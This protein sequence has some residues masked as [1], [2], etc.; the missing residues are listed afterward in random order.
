[1]Y[2]IQDIFASLKN[3]LNGKISFENISF[4]K[5][6][7]W[8]SFDHFRDE[9]RRGISA[10]LTGRWRKDELVSDILHLL[11]TEQEDKVQALLKKEFYSRVMTVL[12]SGKTEETH[13]AL[14][15]ARYPAEWY[16]RARSLKRTIHLHVGPTNSGKTY[17]ALKRLQEVEGDTIY[18]GPLRMLAHEVYTRLNALGKQT[19]LVT[20]D[21]RQ[22]PIGVEPEDYASARNV[23]CTVEMIPFNHEY[24]VA[25]IDEIQ[26]IAD[27][28]RGGSWTSAVLGLPAKELHLCGEERAV[29]IVRQIIAS[30]G[31]KLVI[32]RYQRLTPLE[33]EDRPLTSLGHLQKGD[34]LVSFSVASIHKLRDRIQRATGKQCAI[35]YG[36]LP[37]EVR[38]QQ[39]QLFNDP[40]NDHD[41][42]VAS[43][44]IGMGL[45]LAIKRVIFEATVKNRRD[46]KRSEL[47]VPEIKQ[48]GG[49]AGR[50]RTSYQDTNKPAVAAQPDTVATAAP[51]HLSPLL[52]TQPPVSDIDDGLLLPDSTVPFL[53]E[54][55]DNTLLPNEEVIEEEGATPKEETHPPPSKSEDSLSLAGSISAL[56]QGDLETVRRAFLSEPPPITQ[57]AIQ[58]SQEVISRFYGYFPPGIPYSYIFVRLLDLTELNTDYFLQSHFDTIEI[59]DA[60]ESVADLRIED[61]IA[62]CYAP[63]PMRL[64]V[65]VKLIREM[66]RC[67]ATDSGGSL[68]QLNCISLDVLDSPPDDPDLLPKLETLH[69]GLVLYSWMS[70]RFPGVFVDRALASLTRT[71]TQDAINEALALQNEASRKRGGFR[72]SKLTPRDS[73]EVEDAEFTSSFQP[74]S[75]SEISIR[76]QTGLPIRLSS[77]RN[78]LSQAPIREQGNSPIPR[79][80]MSV[81]APEAPI[82][83]SVSLRR[84]LSYKNFDDEMSKSNHLVQPVDKLDPNL[85]SHIK[86]SKNMDRGIIPTSTHW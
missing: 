55:S 49:R 78:L 51:N 43:D 52:L 56:T 58:P 5:A 13:K 64:N 32:H 74:A 46:Q 16:P 66:A 25:V 1:M 70:F 21:E 60:I 14:A 45:N 44:A 4:N 48:I 30:T 19:W 65:M 40:N 77:G 72:I 15:D 11:E 54:S 17:H 27:P 80:R 71:L 22:Y 6:R 85:S 59:A 3:E 57:A 53:K 23:S 37:S 79:Q 81:S 47:T 67:V 9:V 2:Q 18:A 34:C 62:I 50:Y 76:R 20:G 84:L 24:E 63:V 42:L 10:R 86:N 38:A 75:L 73:T 69:K 31:E 83:K 33:V 35:I 36:S 68:L 39:A 8:E 29:D 26:M 82:R 61:R 12:F 28:D 7:Y 41:F